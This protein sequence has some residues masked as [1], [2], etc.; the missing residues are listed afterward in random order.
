M[1]KSRPPSAWVC[2]GMKAGVERGWKRG[3]C[4]KGSRDVCGWLHP[5]AQG[6]CLAL[7]LTPPPPYCL[8]L[9]SYRFKLDG[10]VEVDIKMGG[11]MSTSYY[12]PGTYR[13]LWLTTCAPTGPLSAAACCT[14]MYPGSCWACCA[15]TCRRQ[16]LPGEAL[17]APSAG[18]PGG[19]AAR[20]PG[21]VEGGRWMCVCWGGGGKKG[22]SRGLGEKRQHLLTG[23]VVT[24]LSRE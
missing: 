10:S 23:T 15:V 9:Q 24:V 3:T 17:H 22:D 18:D 6:R 13:Y 14:T 2:M 21:A 20:P 5:P 1:W 16:H 12:D 4:L 11:Y 8:A 7:Q 19:G